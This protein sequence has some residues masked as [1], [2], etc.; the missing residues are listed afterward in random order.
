MGIDLRCVMCPSGGDRLAVLSRLDDTNLYK[1][2]HLNEMRPRHDESI[3]SCRVCRRL[4]VFNK[5]VSLERTADVFQL[6][7]V[8]PFIKSVIS[9]LLLKYGDGQFV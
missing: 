8:V 6:F 3:C 9:S 2:Q 4:A 7:G 1:E 5:M